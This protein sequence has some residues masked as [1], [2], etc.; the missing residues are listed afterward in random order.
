MHCTI[1]NCCWTGKSLVSYSVLSSPPISCLAYLI[2]MDKNYFLSTVRSKKLKAQGAVQISGH[3]P[4]HIN[5]T[6]AMMSRNR[7]LVT[8]KK[9][10]CQEETFFYPNNTIHTIHKIWGISYNKDLTDSVKP[11]CPCNSLVNKS[12][13]QSCRMIF[14]KYILTATLP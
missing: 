6:F 14:L 13:G 8:C 2:L 12:V 11:G 1:T 10:Y 9:T 7:K 4:L 3:Q 5:T